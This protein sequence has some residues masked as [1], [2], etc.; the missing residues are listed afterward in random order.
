VWFAVCLALPAPSCC[1]LARLWCGPD[2]TPWVS[3][4]YSSPEAAVRTLLEALRRDDPN[5]VYRS[6]SAAYRAHLG[7]DLGTLLVA[8]PQV[9]EQNRGLHLAGYAELLRVVDTGP[10]R[11]RAELLA[12]GYRLDVD[13]VRQRQFEVRY[14]L[15]SG[16]RGEKGH[17]L[18]SFAG[19]L[20]FVPHGDEANGEVVL[21]LRT[22]PFRLASPPTPDDVTFAGVYADWKVGNVKLLAPE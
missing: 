9:R 7:L 6:T 20:E 1:S 13:V 19:A 15:A 4:D 17:A 8:W 10:G 18:E 21:Q 12:E 16:A 14:P 2:R 22:A 3:I 11:A 5:V